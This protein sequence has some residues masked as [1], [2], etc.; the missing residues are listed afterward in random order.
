MAGRDRREAEASQEWKTAAR[1]KA[2][3]HGQETYSIQQT[4]RPK[5]ELGGRDGQC[6]EYLIVKSIQNKTVFFSF[7]EQKALK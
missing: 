1:R 6:P 2:S 5:A 7:Y 4:F 3:Q